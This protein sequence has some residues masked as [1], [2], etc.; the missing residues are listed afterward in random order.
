MAKSGS[1]NTLMYIGIAAAAYFFFLRPQAAAA[2]VPSPA[3]GR[4][5]VPARTGVDAIMPL[6]P[7]VNKIPY[8]AG[9]SQSGASFAAP[10]GPGRMMVYPA[11]PINYPPPGGGVTPAQLPADGWYAS[12]DGLGSIYYRNGQP[13]AQTNGMPVQQ[14]PAGQ[15]GRE[16]DFM[17]APSAGNYN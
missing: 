4:S 6:N 10:G 13:V 8:T 15:T 17:P 1:D 3:V 7:N 2:A 14:P 5:D 11:G 16:I 9:G 12:P